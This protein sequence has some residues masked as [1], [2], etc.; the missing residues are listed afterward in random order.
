MCIDNTIKFLN[1]YRMVMLTTSIMFIV[2][3]YSYLDNV[4][5]LIIGTL[6]TVC[7]YGSYNFLIVTAC[8]TVTWNP[9]PLAKSL[10][11]TMRAIT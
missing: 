2:Y 1:D 5:L 4:L 10:N 9:H 11:E 7:K 8:K 6:L 3:I